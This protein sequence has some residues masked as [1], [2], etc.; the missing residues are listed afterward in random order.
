MPGSVGSLAQLLPC[1]LEV[2]LH[3]TTPKRATELWL[4]CLQLE[5]TIDTNIRLSLNFAEPRRKSFIKKIKDPTTQ[6]TLN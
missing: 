6:S 3:K 5:A 1:S 4:F 2:F